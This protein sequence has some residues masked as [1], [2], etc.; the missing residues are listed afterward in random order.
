[1]CFESSLLRFLKLILIIS[2][3]DISLIFYEKQQNSEII[4]GFQ[5]SNGSMKM[6]LTAW[7]CITT[8]LGFK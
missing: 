5:D 8:S 1:M 3:R 6:S 4:L 2:I 7:W